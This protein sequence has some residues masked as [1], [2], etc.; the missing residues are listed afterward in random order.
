[1]EAFTTNQPWLWYEQGISTQS[2][3]VTYQIGAVLLTGCMGGRNAGAIAQIAYI[4]LGLSGVPVFAK[5]GGFNYI[6]EPGFGYLLGFIPG[7]WL[8]GLIALRQRAKLELLGVSALLGLIVI[9]I[10]GLIYLGILY[11]LPVNTINSLSQLE[12]LVQ[13]HSLNSFP[14]Q[15]AIVCA[16]A[17]IAYFLRRISFY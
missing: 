3:G 14:G 16:V 13:L 9:H 1:M 4:T 2:L 12:R 17:V 15:L 11:L 7:A 6:Q 8:C 10:C 5:G